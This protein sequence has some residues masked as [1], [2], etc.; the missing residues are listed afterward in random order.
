MKTPTISLLLFGFVLLFSFS[1]ATFAHTHEDFLHCLSSISNVIYTPANASYL[2][3]L[4]FSIQNLRFTSPYTPRPLVIVTPLD[5]S[6]IQTTIYCA[7]NHGMEIRTRS[8][9]HD[10]EGLSYTSE[11]SFVVLDL[12]NLR[13][14]IVD[15]ENGTAWVQAGATIGELYY[16][17][18]EKSKNL[19]FSAGICPTVGVG[20]HFSGGGYGTMLRK[21]GLAADNVIDAKLIDVNGNILDR[22][23]MGED[24]FWAIR[25]G[26]GASFGVILA[27]KVHLVVVPSIVTV[28]TINRTLEQ[29]AT[30]LIHKWESIAHKFPQE[31]FIRVLIRKVNS[32]HDGK[33]TILASFNSLYLGEID[34]LIPWMHESF[35]ELGWTREDCIEMSWIESVLYFG[36]FRMG[37]SLDRLLDRTPL[38]KKLYFKAKSDYVTEPIPLFGWKGIWELFFEEEAKLAEMILSPCGGKM[39]EISESSIPFPHR[40]GNLYGIQQLVYWE[41]EGEEE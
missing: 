33:Q 6:Q 39:D 7:N 29:N 3:V 1:R 12:I 14:I 37:E 41:E 8:G 20:G 13:S 38:F 10:Y 40:V 26:G 23:S 30:E 28:F 21:Y 11:D 5:E 18:A 34:Q 17:I 16:K 22:K 24:L 2:S 31:L 27:W 35:P 15:A 25:G 19:G 36:G 4:N 32:S 9:G